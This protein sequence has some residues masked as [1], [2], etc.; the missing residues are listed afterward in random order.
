MA[1]LIP[2]V[3]QLH[4]PG[5]SSREI[6]LEMF[7]SCFVSGAVLGGAQVLERC[8]VTRVLVEDGKVGAGKQIENRNK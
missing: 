5:V 4:M 8:P 2:L 3:L 6:N 7:S 1:Q